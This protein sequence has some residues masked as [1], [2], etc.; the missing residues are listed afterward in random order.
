M[1]NEYVE[2][3]ERIARENLLKKSEEIDG[4]KIK[5]YDFN[6]GLDWDK[7]IDSFASVGFQASN[8]S[9]AIEITRKMISDNSFIFLGYTSNMVSSGNREI[10]RWL[11]YPKKINELSEI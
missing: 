7:V 6:S 1:G 3:N 2:E 11:V 5:G 8:L 9:K 4:V 10:I